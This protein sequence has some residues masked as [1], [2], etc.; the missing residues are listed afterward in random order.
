MKR[1]KNNQTAKSPN[2]P[3]TKFAD[4]QKILDDAVENES[5]GLPHGAFWRNVSR[6]DFVNLKVLGC[7]IIQ[8]EG[9][10]FV[11]DRSL[12]VKILRGS[13]TDCNQR[14]R[15]QMPF[16]FDPVPA[17]KIQ[18]ISDWIDNQCPE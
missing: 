10:L 2:L 14:S 5:V 17:E 3:A 12:L 4:I 6:N 15:P 8:N 16:G 11:G 1:S 7:P 13:V 9:G 18:I